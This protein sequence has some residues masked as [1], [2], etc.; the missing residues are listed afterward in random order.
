MLSI[1]Y[2][3]RRIIL[4]DIL[5]YYPMGE[6]GVRFGLYKI[7][8]NLKR[9]HIGRI[10]KRPNA[11]RVLYVNQTTITVWYGTPQSLAAWDNAVEKYL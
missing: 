9:T 11:V 2:K 7:D 10:L 4:W 6:I 1:Y 3:I 8:Y 5:G